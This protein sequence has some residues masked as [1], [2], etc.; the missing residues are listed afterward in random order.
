[1]SGRYAV[2]NHAGDG[3]VKASSG[4]NTRPAS[5]A[6]ESLGVLGV[7][8]TFAAVFRGPSRP[9]SPS[10]QFDQCVAVTRSALSVACLKQC[11]LILHSRLVARDRGS[12][13]SQPWTPRPS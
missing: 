6:F 7:R 10:V 9:P 1:M 3:V 5:A 8:A 12:T 11:L 4:P 13:R 2:W